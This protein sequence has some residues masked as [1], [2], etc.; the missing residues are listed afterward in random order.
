MGYYHIRLSKKTIKLCTSILLWGKYRY[1]C[2]PKGIANSPEIFQ[3]K[4]NYLFHGFEF[5][6]EYTE[7]L[8]VLTK[9]DW[10]YHVH[11]LELTLKKLK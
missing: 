2:L 1:K 6:R 5:I 7:E 10:A 9:G 11:I 8:L 4:S 3:Q